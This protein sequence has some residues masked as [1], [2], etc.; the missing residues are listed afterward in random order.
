M[1]RTILIA[2]LTALVAT[3]AIAADRQSAPAKEGSAAAKKDKETK[4]CLA[5]EPVTGSRTENKTE[6]RTKSQWAKEG[7]DLDNPES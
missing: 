4:Y 3:P 7:I 5:F 1:S 2:A 6:C